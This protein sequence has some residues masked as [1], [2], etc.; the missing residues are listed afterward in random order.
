MIVEQR[1]TTFQV[2]WARANRLRGER[3]DKLGKREQPGT[4]GAQFVPC[5]IWICF[6]SQD[7]FISGDVDEVLSRGA[8]HQLKWCQVREDVITGGH[9]Q[10]S[11]FWEIS[12]DCKRSP[13]D[14]TGEA[15]SRSPNRLPR[16]CKASHLQPAHY[17][18][19]AANFNS[20]RPSNASS[21][22]IA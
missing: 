10:F 4:W 13:L 14:A 2:C 5:Q 21:A 9:H 18:Q 17:L 16:P 15:W 22:K 3:S 6:G 7:L 12:F 19:G 20:H 8:L 1:R 11:F